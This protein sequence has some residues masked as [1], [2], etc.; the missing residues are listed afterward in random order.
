MTETYRIEAIALH[1]VGVFDD[2]RIDFPKIQSP[3]RDAQKAEI[4]VL[5]GPNGCGKSTLLYALAE[6]FDNYDVWG[7]I[8]RRFRNDNSHVDFLFSQCPGFYGVHQETTSN[9]FGEYYARLGSVAPDGAYVFALGLS[10]HNHGW[11]DLWEYK[12]AQKIFSKSC[13][14]RH[15]TVAS[16]AAFAYSGQRSFDRTSLK[17]IQEI[18]NSPFESAL[19]FNNMVRQEVL[20]QW[21]A[22]NRAQSA[23]AKADG[24]LSAAQRY[25]F[26]LKRVTQAI[27]EIC[28]LDIEFRLERQPLAVTLRV[29][30]DIIQFDTLPDGLKSIISWIG[31]LSV[32]LEMIPWVDQ[33]KDIFAQNLILFLDEIDIHLHPKWQRKILPV[34]QKLFP[35]SQIFVSTHSPFVVGSVED[36]WIYRLPEKGK[37]TE[38]VI[39]PVPSGAGKSYRLI[40][41]EIFDVDK[42]FDVETESLFDSFYQYRE[43]FLRT[44]Q[45][46]QELITTARD[47][48]AKG[49][50]TRAIVERELRQISRITGKELKFA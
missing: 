5:T 24:D 16:Y 4:H 12:K 29:G 14:P 13:P 37:Q 38:R 42:E 27:K 44:Q 11:Q 10:K 25:D 20:W 3:E 36:A 33:T 41:E 21:I 39:K 32:R 48:A 19:S 49:E 47:L 43:N 7:P 28:D 9:E 31:D 2:V 8:R 50:E 30:N 1:E 40:L 22:N 26:S 35:N 6:I 23:L 15:N 18:N 46:E 45:N 34:I 17:A